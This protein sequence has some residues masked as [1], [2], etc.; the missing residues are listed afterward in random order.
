MMITFFHIISS[1][2]I[3]KIKDSAVFGIQRK[4]KYEFISRLINAISHA[5]KIFFSRTEVAMAVIRVVN[6]HTNKP[7]TLKFIKSSYI[8]GPMAMFAYTAVINKLT[9]GQL[10]GNSKRMVEYFFLTTREKF[11]SRNPQLNDLKKF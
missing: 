7:F 11:I 9:S 8:E 1:P 3:L 4:H 10:L 5:I 2:L 6:T